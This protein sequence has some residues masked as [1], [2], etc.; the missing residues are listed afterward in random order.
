MRI[1]EVPVG[2]VV[3]TYC[4][5]TLT[6]IHAGAHDHAGDGPG[7]IAKP[8]SRCQAHAPIE[9]LG[10]IDYVDDRCYWGDVRYDPLALELEASF[11]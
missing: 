3:T 7:A 11:G 5:C 8:I 10:D 1:S 2:G 4:G 6:I 9:G